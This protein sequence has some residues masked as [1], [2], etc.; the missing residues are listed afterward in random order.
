[1]SNS[2]DKRSVS[3]DALETLGTIIGPNEKRD[4]IHIAVEPVEATQNLFP[5][6]HIKIVDGK[7]YPAP[8]GQGHGIVDPFLPGMVKKGQRFWFL[9]YPR[10]VKSLRHVWSH[11]D[12]ADEGVITVE[13]PVKETK[14]KA[15]SQQY[16]DDFAS[17]MGFSTEELM[18]AVEN[19]HYSNGGALV[20][21]GQDAGG[22][23][24]D[25]FW[26]HV[27]VITGKKYPR[28]GYFSCSC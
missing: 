9:M 26:D 10:Q 16:I 6:V 21:H 3:T 11:P 23:I 17:S 24:P 20:I 25:E 22:D 2:A 4:A 14:N 5:G 18:E 1:M 12:F 27:E 7:A 8:L 13:V 15:L 19:N 28:A